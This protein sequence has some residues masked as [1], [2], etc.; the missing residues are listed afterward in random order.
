MA[1]TAEP[2]DAARRV[3]EQTNAFRQSEGRSALAR[4]EVLEAA[5][6]EFARYMARTGRYGHGADGRTPVERA[7]AAG[8][9]HCVVAENIAYQYSSAGFETGALARA[10]VEGWKNS[11]GHRRNMLDDA[12]SE[13]AVAIV[14]APDGRYFAVQM[15]GR[16]KRAAIRFSIANAGRRQAAYRLGEKRHVLPPR[17][18]RTHLIC[19]ESTLELPGRNQLTPRDGARYTIGAR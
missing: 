12:V 1:W 7:N 18:V 6:L 16:P 15:F 13:T 14:Q 4:D 19:R 11:P 8:Y 17:G 3:V 10:L 5:A 2:A 9:E